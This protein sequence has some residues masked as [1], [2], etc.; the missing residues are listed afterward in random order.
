MRKTDDPKEQKA[1]ADRERAYIRL[2]T[3]SLGISAVLKEERHYR[4]AV[5]EWK[6]IL[7]MVNNDL[8]DAIQAAALAE[9]AYEPYYRRRRLARQ[10]RV[11]TKKKKKAAKTLVN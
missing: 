1:R 9:E 8:V 6:P 10:Y 2:Q 3:I 11:A 5:E 4:C 7:E